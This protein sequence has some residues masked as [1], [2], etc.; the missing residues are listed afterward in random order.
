MIEI[1]YN[2][3]ELNVKNINVIKNSNFIVFGVKWNNFK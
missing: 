2:I 3:K 1:K